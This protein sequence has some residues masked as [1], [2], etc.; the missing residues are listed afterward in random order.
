MEKTQTAV[1]KL[2]EQA[3]RYMNN[4][5]KEL[6]LANKNGKYYQ[7]AKQCSLACGAAYLATLKA[8]DGLFLLRGIPKPKRR[9]SIDYYRLGLINVDRKI[10]QS[11]NTTYQVLHL[12]GY[13]EGLTNIKT[14]ASG[15]EEAQWIINKLKQSF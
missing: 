8:L 14:I 4:A 5:H 15:F 9:A 6:V 7:D 3:E 11:L 10:L 1:H 12:N 2:L 13:Y